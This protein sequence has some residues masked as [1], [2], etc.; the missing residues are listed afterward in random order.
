MGNFYEMQ[1]NQVILKLA[2]QFRQPPQDAPIQFSLLYS[3][4][5][6]NRKS[7]K[8]LLCFFEFLIEFKIGKHTPSENM[9]REAV[10]MYG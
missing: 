4:K 3:E 2:R 10:K 5:N 8:L 9:V 7:T 1:T 6:R